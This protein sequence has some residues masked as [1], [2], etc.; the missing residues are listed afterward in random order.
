[1]TTTI[2][3]PRVLVLIVLSNSF[4]D[5][6]ITFLV[7]GKQVTKCF[8]EGEHVNPKEYAKKLEAELS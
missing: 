4:G 3:V 7:D 5:Q 1:M 2:K 8:T 6:I